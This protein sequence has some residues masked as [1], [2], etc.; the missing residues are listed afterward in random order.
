MGVQGSRWYQMISNSSNKG[1][2]SHL[3]TQEV[4]LELVWMLLS[5]M[6][7]VVHGM[8]SLLR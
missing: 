6:N 3:F 2:K 8:W 1:S 7:D 5:E 4:F